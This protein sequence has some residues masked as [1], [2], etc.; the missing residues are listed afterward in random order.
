[1]DVLLRLDEADAGLLEKLCADSGANKSVILRR[2]LRA[3][4]NGGAAAGVDR[5]A[6]LQATKLINGVVDRLAEGYRLVPPDEPGLAADAA[7]VAE[8]DLCPAV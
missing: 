8:V 7:A 1:V 6:I 2:A 4:G 5:E 3:L